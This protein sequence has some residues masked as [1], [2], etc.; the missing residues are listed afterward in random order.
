MDD[1]KQCK[2]PSPLLPSLCQ[3]C[4]G[5]SPDFGRNLRA[6]GRLREATRLDLVQPILPTP[7]D[8]YGYPLLLPVLR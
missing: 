2:G 7:S 3:L 1:L 4:K 8:G 6:V 5:L